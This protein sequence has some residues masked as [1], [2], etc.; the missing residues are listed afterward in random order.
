MK[1]SDLERNQR[2]HTASVLLSCLSVYFDVICYC[3]TWALRKSN[4]ANSSDL[5][6]GKDLLS[7]DLLY[8]RLLEGRPYYALKTKAAEREPQGRNSISLL[9]WKL[10][11]WLLEVFSA[12]KQHQKRKRWSVLESVDIA[13][14]QEHSKFPRVLCV[15]ELASGFWLIV[16]SVS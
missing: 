4:S 1:S 16:H 11:F 15:R 8:Q 3:G 5:W 6:E 10:G 14:A 13:K 2:S 7:H 12:C 9:T